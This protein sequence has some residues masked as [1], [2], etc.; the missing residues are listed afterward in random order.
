MRCHVVHCVAAHTDGC[1]GKPTH[2]RLY[3]EPS[4]RLGFVLVLTNYTCEFTPCS[5][6]KSGFQTGRSLRSYTTYYMFSP[7]NS[8]LHRDQCLSPYYMKFSTSITDTFFFMEYIK[9]IDQYS[10]RLSYHGG[11]CGRTLWN[12]PEKLHGLAK[13]SE[14]TVLCHRIPATLPQHFIVVSW[15]PCGSRFICA[16]CFRVM[17]GSHNM[18]LPTWWTTAQNNVVGSNS[19][20]VERGIADPKAGCSTHSCSLS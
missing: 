7:R 4:P 14:T 13:C 12:R 19:S 3:L 15:S 16:R 1:N 18:L 10:P 20:V 9:R 2:A 11:F 6:M 5:S 17:P 8:S